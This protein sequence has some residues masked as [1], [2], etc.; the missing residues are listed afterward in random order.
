MSP[1]VTLEAGRVAVAERRWSDA[2]EYLGRVDA[3]DGLAARDLELLSTAALLRGLA[4]LAEDAGARAYAAHVAASDVAAAAR[5]A[6]WLALEMVELGDFSGSVTWSARAMRLAASVEEPGPI[7]GFARLGPGVAQLGSGDAAESRRTFEEVRAVAERYGDDELDANAS[8]GLAKSL[9]E[10][11]D[12]AAGFEAYDR[13]IGAVIAGR[14]GPVT[15]G[16]ICCVGISDALTAF[17]L[18]RAEAW[19]DLLD[20][21]CRTQPSLVTFSGQRHALRAALQLVH[22]SWDRAAESI[23][24]ALSGLRAGDFRATYGA[25]YQAAELQRL[26]GA[27]HSAEA[28]Y[29]RAADSGWEPQPGLALLHLVA[30]RIQRA[31]AEVRRNAAGDDRFTRVSVLPAVVEVE[32]AAGDLSAARRAAD[33]LHRAGTARSTPMFEAVVAASEARVRL[34]FGD[35]AGARQAAADAA[36]RFDA[37]GAP[38]DAARCRVIAGRALLGLG[39]RGSADAEFRAAR[40]VFQRLSAEPALADLAELMGS[41]RTGTLT[42]REVEVLRLVSTGLTNRSIAA[43]LTLSERTVERH[44][45]NI[46][47]KLGISSRAAATAYAYENGLV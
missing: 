22:G 26:R 2:V 7:V 15:T 46:F 25:P 18:G 43:R 21:W 30:G 38:Y 47:G 40:E 28:S 37:I 41:R 19:T 35:V 23:E 42:A 34:A 32:I 8:L 6:G 27:V 1:S 3:A 33:E 16:V 17:D 20:A 45:S 36:S 9:L 31:Q 24:S 13:A 12:V 39:D 29:R 4:D 5:V 11:G 44:L 14:T 10:L